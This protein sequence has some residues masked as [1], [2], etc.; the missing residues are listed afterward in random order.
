VTRERASGLPLLAFTTV[1]AMRY[2]PEGIG[3][4]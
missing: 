4:R 3:V 2:G 1:P